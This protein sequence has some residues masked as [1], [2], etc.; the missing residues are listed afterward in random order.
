MKINTKL[1][2]GSW[3][4]WEDGVE[5]KLRPFPISQMTPDLTE[6]ELG[7]K[8]FLYCV[9]DWKGII[10]EDTDKQVR[11]SDKMKAYL[12]DHFPALTNFVAIT[13]TAMMDKES[14]LVKN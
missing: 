10:D 14:K 8:M 5:L 7:Q 3:F 1:H 2:K 6:M 12:Y 4:E 9:V 11:V 13:I